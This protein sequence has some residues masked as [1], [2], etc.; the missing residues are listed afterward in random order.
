MD[1]TGKIAPIHMRTDANHL[2]TTA[3]TTH[4]PEQRETIHMSTQLRTEAISGAIDDLAH[5][6]SL[7]CLA[8]PLT[9]NSAKPEFL[10]KA[11]ATGLLPN[12]DRHP[13]F[14]ELMAGRHKAYLSSWIVM[15]LARP[16][17]IYTLLGQP[18]H[19]QVAYYL[20]LGS[21]P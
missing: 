7:D 9:K 20:S 5:V 19:R 1:M 21:S 6:V 13:P 3:Q 11:I 15:N 14:R 12:V 18:A 8:D 2:V 10:I 16:S 4:L 17:D